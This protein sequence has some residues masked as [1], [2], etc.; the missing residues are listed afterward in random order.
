MGSTPVMELTT[1]RADALDALRG[2]A[3]LLMIL[4]GNIHFANPLPAWMYHAQVPPPAFVFTPDQP[5]ITWVDLVF[6]FFLFAMGAAF[7]F[8]L[9]R[10]LDAGVARWKIVLQI[11]LRGILLTGF[12]IYIQHI[13]PFAFSADPTT[14]DW[15]IGLL[16]FALLFPLLLRLPRTL[17]PV[18]RFGIRAA[19]FL[20]AAG[21]LWYITFPDGTGFSLTRSDI[22]IIVLANVAVFGSLIWLV[23]RDR[24]LPRLGVLG[25]LIALRLTQSID[26]SWNQWLWHFSPFPWMYSLYYLQ[27]LFIVL[28]GTIVGDMVY[29]WMNSPEEADRLQEE[30]TGQPALVLLLMMLLLAVNVV[31]LYARMVLVTAIASGV[32]C[33]AGALLLARARTAIGILHR[34]L[35]AWGTY[36]LVLGFVFE[37]YEGGIKK[38]HPTM[39]YYF[40]TTGLAIFA[41]VAFSVV[42]EQ[43]NKAKYIRII[44][45]NGQNPLIAYIAGSTLV[46]PLLAVTHLNALLDVLSATPWLGFVR[47]LVFTSLVALV[48]SFFTKRH[49]FWRT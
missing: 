10:K 27:Y 6:P 12:A 25:I 21:L 43:F 20:G 11:I 33:A 44:I 48:T 34:A 47:G 28:P 37:A 17:K 45:E 29:R 39:S 22:I 40:V 38:D 14:G 7:P 30:P 36:W 16:G 26:G 3:I 1:K 24:V 35:V 46:L 31:G 2:L 42:C 18:A 19:G 8:A 15:L 49:M 13:K 9:S 32:L 41:F 5:G 4:S 23:T